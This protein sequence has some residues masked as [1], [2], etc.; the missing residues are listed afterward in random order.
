MKCKLQEKVEWCLPGAGVEGM[1]R[2]CSNDTKWNKF[3]GSIYVEWV[4]IGTHLIVTLLPNVCIYQIT[5]M[6][7]LNMYDLCQENT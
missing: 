3:W 6:Y 5:T 1:G 7:T 4:V 2:C